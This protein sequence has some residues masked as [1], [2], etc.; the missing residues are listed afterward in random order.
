[1]FAIPGVTTWWST[2]LTPLRDANSR[3]YRLIGTSS[4]ITPVKQAQE[5]VGLQVER[6]QLLEA[7]AGRIHQS[8]ELETIL[9]QTTIELRQFLNCD[10]ILIYRFQADGSGVIVAASVAASDSLLGKTS[11]IPALVAIQKTTGKVAF[12]LLRIFMQQTCILT[13]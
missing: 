8:V 2:T 3:I 1:M 11:S 7:I 6:E 13:I 5:A 9:H 12:K 4:N 10:R